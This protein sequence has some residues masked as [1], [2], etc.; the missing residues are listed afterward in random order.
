MVD[1]CVVNLSMVLMTGLVVSQTLCTPENNGGVINSVDPNLVA[2]ADGVVNRHWVA[3]GR[4]SQGKRRWRQVMEFA[5]RP[6]RVTHRPAL[7]LKNGA[8]DER[9]SVDRTGLLSLFS[10]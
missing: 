9:R 7:L 5:S 3:V 4:R 10:H 2:I 6:T 8:L 1:H